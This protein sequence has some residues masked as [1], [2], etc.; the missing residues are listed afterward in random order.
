MQITVGVEALLLLVERQK[1]GEQV[2][3][4]IGAVGHVN[5]KIIHLAPRSVAR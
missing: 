1:P 5:G 3:N 4:G 2:V